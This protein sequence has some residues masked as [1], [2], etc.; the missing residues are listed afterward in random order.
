MKNVWTRAT[1]RY[2][3][4]SGVLIGIL[5]LGGMVATAAAAGQRLTLEQCLERALTYSP[6]VNEVQTEIRI[7]ESQL[8]QAKAG[9]LPQ[10][11]FTG[12]NG[13]VNGAEG[14]A[15][16][17]KTTSHYGPFSRGELEIV[18]PLYTLAQLSWETLAASHG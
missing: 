8:A 1:R 15:V 17:G 4:L 7:A 9:R 6:D 5:L 11:N 14:N 2:Y 18:Q 10:A 13:V 16:T 12:L 3:L